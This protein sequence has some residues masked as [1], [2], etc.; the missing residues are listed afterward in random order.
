[1]MV[2]ELI[3]TTLTHILHKRSNYL[4]R[5]IVFLA[6]VRNM[7]TK[8]SV[9]INILLGLLS[10]AMLANA[11]TENQ[12]HVKLAL[13]VDPSYLKQYGS[14]TPL[15][16]LPYDAL[17]ELSQAE[18]GLPDLTLWFRVTTKSSLL[19]GVS[20]DFITDYYFIPSGCSSTAASASPSPK[21]HTR[22]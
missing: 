18:P 21:W 9:V 1:M 22:L 11:T 17:R 7:S 3:L 10:S 8:H 20:K 2:S 4:P 16:S 6:T 15:F 5:K 12:A 14:A 13:G 19:R